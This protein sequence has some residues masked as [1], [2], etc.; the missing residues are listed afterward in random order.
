MAL[1]DEGELSMQA[2][3]VEDSIQETMEDDI[4]EEDEEEQAG[5]DEDDSD[6]EKP[7]WQAEQVDEETP[8]RH[9]IAADIEKKRAKNAGNSS[10]K[11]VRKFWMLL[12]RKKV[13][14][15]KCWVGSYRICRGTMEIRSRVN[16]LRGAKGML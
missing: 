13:R 15:R 6:Y 8:N 14:C 9:S 5:Q 3:Q 11:K 10:Q 7:P 16:S 1:E 12:T 4:E 2:G